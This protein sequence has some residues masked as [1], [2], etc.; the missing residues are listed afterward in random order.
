MLSVT[1]FANL[2]PTLILLISNLIASLSVSLAL[3]SSIIA[4]SVPLLVTVI[5][6]SILSP[7]LFNP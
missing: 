5:L 4:S 3:I 1:P 2:S 7:G 6:Y